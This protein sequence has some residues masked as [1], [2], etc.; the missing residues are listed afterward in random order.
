MSFAKAF[1]LSLASNQSKMASNATTEIC[2]GITPCKDVQVASFLETAKADGSATRSG[3]RSE[4]GSEAK[5]GSKSGSESGSESE[6][7]GAPESGSESKKRF[8]PLGINADGSCKTTGIAAIHVKRCCV[9]IPGL[10]SRLDGSTP[11]ERHAAHAVEIRALC[12]QCVDEKKKRAF[13][14]EASAW[15]CADETDSARVGYNT[16]LE[17]VVPPRF[18]AAQEATA[19]SEAEAEA[20]AK[21]KAGSESEAEAEV[22]SV[23]VVTPFDVEDAADRTGGLFRK[24]LC[25]GTEVGVVMQVRKEIERQR[26]VKVSMCKVSSFLLLLLLFGR[27]ICVGDTDF[28]RFNLS[29]RH[30]HSSPPPSLFLSIAGRARAQL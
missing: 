2:D 21:G 14:N 26:C 1:S 9:T 23:R 10:T 18:R 3:T 16:L 4:S 28:F 5:G 12:E 30:S 19:G 6:S 13:K 17:A 22:G 11:T 20:G 24:K 25:P 29:S 7:E 8:G 27:R 15:V